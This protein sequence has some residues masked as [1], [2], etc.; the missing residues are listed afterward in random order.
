MVLAYALIA[1]VQTVHTDDDD[2]INLE[3][4]QLRILVLMTNEFKF[5]G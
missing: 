2:D 4:S 3:N 1:A 5:N